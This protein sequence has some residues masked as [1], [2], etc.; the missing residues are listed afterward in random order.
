MPRPIPARRHNAK[1][2]TPYSA[3][4]S[5]NASLSTDQPSRRCHRYAPRPW[6]A[7]TAA[8]NS[9]AAHASSL[10]ACEYDTCYS[11]QE[12]GEREH[13]REQTANGTGEPAGATEPPASP[14]D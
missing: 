8:A 10:A 3:A 13:Q 12:D 11:L 6:T 4:D 2:P 7:A 14:A 5:S 9:S 1:R